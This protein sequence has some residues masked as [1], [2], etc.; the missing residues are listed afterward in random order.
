MTNQLKYVLAPFA[1]SVVVG[2]GEPESNTSGTDN[3]E[4][5]NPVA[6]APEA[7]TLGD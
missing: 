2:C 7:D 5:N 3:T 1:L 6:V 4:A